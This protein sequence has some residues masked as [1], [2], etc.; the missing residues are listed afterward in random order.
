MAD[1]TYCVANCPHIKC[2]RHGSKIAELAKHGQKY[3]S[4]ADFA[5]VCR[6]YIAQVVE[7]V[8]KDEQRQNPQK[9]RKSKKK[10]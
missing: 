6:E 4:V 9:N 8:V 2:E 7:E 1:M 5:P 10:T 3:V